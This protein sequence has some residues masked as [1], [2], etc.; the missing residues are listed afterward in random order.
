MQP[1]DAP[2]PAQRFPGH[3]PAQPDKVRSDLNRLRNWRDGSAAMAL[4]MG[5]LLPLAIAWHVAYLVA[6]AASL[7]AATLI[8]LATHRARET[9]LTALAKHTQFAT[10]PELARKRK[11]LLSERKRRALA[12]GLRRTASPAQPPT[13]F[14]TCPIL[15]DR[16]ARVRDELLQIADRVEHVRDPD[17]TCIA[18][19]QE[20]LTN[21]CGPLYNRNV[22]EADLHAT[23]VRARAGLGP[24]VGERQ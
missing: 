15:L 21:A 14:D 11:L 9:C 4:T 5:A 13:R 24:D 10:D 23:L 12:A 19:I 7:I 6:I 22:P 8:A 2:A 3:T 18:L 17:P 1:H 20:L 16:V